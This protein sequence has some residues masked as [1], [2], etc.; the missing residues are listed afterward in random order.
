MLFRPIDEMSLIQLFLTTFAKNLEVE[1][2]REGFT[3]S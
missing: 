2:N 1:L 3:S